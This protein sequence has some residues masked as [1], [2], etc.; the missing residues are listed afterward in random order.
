MPNQ[1]PVEQE[2]TQ[3]WHTLSSR[4]VLQD[5]GVAANGL[6]AE[7]AQ[8]RLEQFGPNQLSEARRPGF[9]SMLWDQFK[10]FVVLLLIA[11]SLISIFL[12]EIVDA[13]AIMSIVVLNSASSRNAAPKKPW[14]RSKNSPPPKRMSCAMGSA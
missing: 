8:K 10:D 2:E 13:A 14:P 6:S 1:K 9:L 3:N 7:E 4:E 5:L 12:G 11:A